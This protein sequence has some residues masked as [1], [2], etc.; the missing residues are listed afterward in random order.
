MLPLEEAKQHLLNMIESCDI[1]VGH[2]V[3]NDFKFIPNTL[4]LP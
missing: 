3:N 1:I 4:N 2:A